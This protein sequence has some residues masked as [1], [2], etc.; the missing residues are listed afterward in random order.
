MMAGKPL[1]QS[2][3]EP[4][5]QR[6]LRCPQCG[7]NHFWVVYTR[8]VW[9][10]RIIRRRECRYCGRRM[11]TTERSIWHIQM[12]WKQSDLLVALGLTWRS[13]GPIFAS[14][15]YSPPE[16][17]PALWRGFVFFPALATE[18]STY[19]TIYLIIK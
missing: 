10:G 4:D 5:K 19:V 3:P 1:T 6:G 9:G 7:C 13:V 14:S 2:Q 12:S 17:P 8:R 16:Q 15:I 18:M 11:T